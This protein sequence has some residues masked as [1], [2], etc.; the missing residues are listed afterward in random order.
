MICGAITWLRDFK[1]KALEEQLTHAADEEEP[2]WVL[3]H[4][5]KSREQTLASQEA[6]SLNG[7]NKRRR[8]DEDEG[9]YTSEVAELLREAKDAIGRPDV[10]PRSVQIIYASRTHSQLTQF[11]EELKKPKF[12]DSYRGTTTAKVKHVTLGSRQHLCIHEDVRKLTSLQAMN[13]ACRAMQE[14]NAK[15]CPYLSTENESLRDLILE[16]IID[17][18]ELASIG[19][20]RKICPYYGARD[21]VEASEVITVA[22]PA[23]FHPS[24]RESNSLQLKDSIVIIDEAHNVMNAISD[25]FTITVRLPQVTYIIESLSTYRSKAGYI[26]QL[27]KTLRMIESF[28]LI[29]KTAGEVSLSDILKGGLDQMNFYELAKKL[30][31]ARLGFKF[32][33]LLQIQSFLITLMNPA[34]EGRIFFGI[35]ESP[36][37]KYMLLDVRPTFHQSIASA[38]SVI[39][40]GGTMSPVNDYVDLFDTTVR[41]YSYDHIVPS[42]NISI[43]TLACT[44]QHEFDFTLRFRSSPQMMDE[45]GSVIVNLCGVIPHGVIIFFPSYNY[46]DT[47]VSHWQKSTIYNRLAHRKSVFRESRDFDTEK[48]LEEYTDAIAAGGAVLLSVVGGKLSEGINFANENGRGVIMVGL[49]FPNVTSPEWKIKTDYISC[50]APSAHR[51]SIV[52]DYAENTC[53]RAVNQS[54][55][56]VIRHK[57]DYAMIYLL[58]KRYAQARIRDKLPRWLQKSNPTTSATYP[59][60]LKDT[61]TFFRLHT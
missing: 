42:Q 55:G 58:D 60:V 16:D 30:N 33:A 6:G 21:A 54:I 13:E 43:A 50:S 51:E 5:Q 22:Y 24:V 49:P 53:M 27:L 1:R 23:L 17:I 9:I 28:L 15:R 59:E 29:S 35:D 19:K 31:G 26:Q 36:Y 47:V 8:T 18:E 14:P 52:Q 25:L 32:P 39:L 48:L 37:L 45:L 20:S 40:A 4:E 2:S 44:Q 34:K 38:R 56:R 3:E 57:S 10:E 12:P 46:L 7:L 11:I 61:A 41:T